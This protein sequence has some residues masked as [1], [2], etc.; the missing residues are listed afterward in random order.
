MFRT[1]APDQCDC[2][3]G[4]YRGSTTCAARRTYFVQV[5][6]DKRPGI[7]PHLVSWQMVQFE[8]RCASMC[9]A[10]EHAVAPGRLTVDQLALDFARLLCD[11]L[12]QFFLIHPY[13]NGN[14][15]AG[16]LLVCV[17]MARYGYDP[18]MWPID[19]R[20]PYEQALEEYGN[21]KRKPL[22][23]ILLRAMR[24]Q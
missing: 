4:H 20:P 17:L 6:D 12:E 10:L 2:L 8:Q 5:A 19:E 24:G 3:A 13:A 21:G 16:R 15:H 1:L 14:G 22:T 11:V 23:T 7:W 18:A 9:A